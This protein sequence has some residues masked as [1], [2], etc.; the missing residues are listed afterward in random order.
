MINQAV[1]QRIEVRLTHR[2]IDKYFDVFENKVKTERY[3]RPS[4]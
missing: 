1:I 4:Y 2:D 3:K